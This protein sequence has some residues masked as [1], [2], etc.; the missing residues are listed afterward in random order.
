MDSAQLT[1]FYSYPGEISYSYATIINHHGTNYIDKPMYHSPYL[2]QGPFEEIL[3]HKFP[4]S[5]EKDLEPR[6]SGHTWKE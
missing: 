1:M 2:P 4:Q 3:M 6:L 5:K